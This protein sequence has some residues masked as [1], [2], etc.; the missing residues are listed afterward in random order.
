MFT[1]PKSKSC[2]FHKEI[3]ALPMVDEQYTD[4]PSRCSKWMGS[5]ICY[6]TFRKLLHSNSKHWTNCAADIYVIVQATNIIS[7][8]E[9]KYLQLVVFISVHD[10]VAVYT[11]LCYGGFLSIQGNDNEDGLAKLGA[12]KL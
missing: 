12:S 11:M 6:G 8:T 1:Y 7:N 3:H 9:E 5:N 10:I 4:T 2:A